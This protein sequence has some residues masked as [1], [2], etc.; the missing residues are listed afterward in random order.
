VSGY[1][2]RTV[3][4][5]NVEAGWIEPFG[6]VRT[7][8]GVEVDRVLSPLERYFLGG[9]NSIR[10]HRYRSIFVRDSQGNPVVDPAFPTIGL[11]GDRYFQ[12]NLEYHV[13]LGGPFRII[14]YVDGGNVF[15]SFDEAFLDDEGNQQ[16]RRIDQSYD[17]ST[18][19]WTAGAE[20]R[21]L[22]PVFGAP[23]RFIYAVNLDEQVGDEFDSFRFSIGA[24]F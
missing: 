7:S 20:L 21:L 4:G 6:S 19:R 2:V 17:L 11:G 10:G 16:V 12:V 13:L 9:E 18:L 22:L 24:A 5:I 1:P 23:L 14:F 8:E 3:F 15:G